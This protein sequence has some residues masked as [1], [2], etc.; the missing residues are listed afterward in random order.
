MRQCEAKTKQGRRC[1]NRTHSEN[2][3]FCKVHT[4]E[5][6]N[7]TCPIC[8]CE[9]SGDET[10]C[11]PPCG[12]AFH[13]SCLQMWVTRGNIGCPL[14]RKV[15]HESYEACRKWAP[16]RPEERHTFDSVLI[17]AEHEEPSIE[18]MQW[19][20][21]NLSL[22]A[23]GVKNRDMMTESLKITINTDKMKIVMW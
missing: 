5:R 6:A 21:Y 1:L 4:C 9:L 3:Y 18:H 12:H 14:C 15:L 10:V 2:P 11:V 17:E 7:T 22:L 13:K 16:D 20:V 19:L 8:L 23:R